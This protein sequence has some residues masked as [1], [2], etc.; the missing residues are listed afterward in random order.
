MKLSVIVLTLALITPA[1]AQST[2]PKTV[3]LY[4]NKSGQVLG[5]ATISGNRVYLRDSKGELVGTA[6]Y[7]KDKQTLY[8]PSGNI[9][10]KLAIMPPEQ[11]PADA[12]QQQ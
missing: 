7:V 6:V 9:V 4:D 11:I 10:D 12:V 8:D 2:I 5:T 1:A 3:K